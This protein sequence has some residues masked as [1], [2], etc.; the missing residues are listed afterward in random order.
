MNKTNSEFCIVALDLK[1]TNGNVT[2]K[3]SISRVFPHP[4]DEL[5]N[6]KRRFSSERVV[7]GYSGNEML[8]AESL[9]TR[10]V[11]FLKDDWH[12]RILPK[13]VDN[14]DAKQNFGGKW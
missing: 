13:F 1:I 8:L 7:G 2:W 3:K 6:A 5:W 11:S 4:S 14:F 12:F 9:S 10:K